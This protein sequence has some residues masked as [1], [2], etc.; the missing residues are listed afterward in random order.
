MEEN[1][2]LEVVEVKEEVKLN[3]KSDRFDCECGKNI[4]L[5]NKSIHEKTKA[6][7]EAVFDKN[8]EKAEDN[9]KE[10]SYI[11]KMLKRL[12]DKCDTIFESLGYLLQVFEEEAEL[13]DKE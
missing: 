12:D 5:K 10:F 13:E 6:H 4:L 2:P 8:I 9:D 3:V 11:C 7:K 1:K